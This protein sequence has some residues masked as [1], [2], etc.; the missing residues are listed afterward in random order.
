M[1]DIFQFKQFS[2]NQDQCAMKVGTDGVL[3]GAWINLF[4][5]TRRI[6]DV[7]SGTGLIAL[8]LAQRVPYSKIDGI[9]Q[10]AKAYEQG[11][12]NF[13]NS[14][15]DQNL[16]NFHGTFQEFARE[17]ERCYDLIVCNPPFFNQGQVDKHDQRSMAR[18]AKALPIDAIVKGALDLLILSGRLA[19]ILPHDDKE[20]VMS[21]LESHGMLLLRMTSVRGNESKPPKRLLIEAGFKTEIN[22]SIPTEFRELIIEHSRHNHTEQ[23]RDLVREFYLK[24]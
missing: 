16:Y 6:L 14:P 4:S 18:N 15:W 1:R 13:Q 19:M 12:D 10:D 20:L 3:L 5:D 22:R 23:Y 17:G 11:V 21:I 7:G 2:L 24:I 8:M 9:E